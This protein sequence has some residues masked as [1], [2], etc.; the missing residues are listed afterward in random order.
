MNGERWQNEHVFT[1]DDGETDSN[2]VELGAGAF[3]TLIVEAGSDL[4]GKTVQFFAVSANRDSPNFTSV[5]LL[6]TAITLGVGSN[7]LTAEE[8]TEVGAIGRCCLV[9]NSAVSGDQS[10]VIL[11]KS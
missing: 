3:G 10:L 6:S 5:G 1:W 9:V 8:I 4:I 11:W 2:E 7:A